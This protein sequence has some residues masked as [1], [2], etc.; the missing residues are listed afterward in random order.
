MK[1]VVLL[2]G[3]PLLVLLM[4]GCSSQISEEQQVLDS[5]AAA[6]DAIDERDVHQLQSLLAEDVSGPEQT[7]RDQLTTMMQLY[8][9]QYRHV[10]VFLRDTGIELQG[11]RADVTTIASVVGA[12]ELWPDRARQFE[13]RMRW[14]R[15]P[16]GWKLQ[17]IHWQAREER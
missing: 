12:R 9:R 10:R 4:L 7:R 2:T 15:Q 5:L 11:P 16:D 6:V 1:T 14:T 17:R 13:V 8:F 3:I